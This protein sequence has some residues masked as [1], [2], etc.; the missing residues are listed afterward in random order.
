MIYK[1]EFND[2]LK[3]DMEKDYYYKIDYVLDDNNYYD[4]FVNHLDE[5]EEYKE[6][7]VMERFI[8]Y[9]DINNIDYQL[10]EMYYNTIE[11][12]SFYDSNEYISGR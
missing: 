2:F 4:I 9:L 8:R 3:Y 7:V 5:I 1:K 10:E 6:D 11:Y 12:I